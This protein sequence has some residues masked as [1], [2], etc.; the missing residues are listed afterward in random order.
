MTKEP[1]SFTGARERAIILQQ[2]GDI[3]V[4]VSEDYTPR[5]GFRFVTKHRNVRNIDDV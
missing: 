4:G 3:S 5:A 2:T 1:E